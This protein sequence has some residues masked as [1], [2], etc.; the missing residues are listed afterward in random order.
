[1]LLWNVKK[2]GGV[3]LAYQFASRVFVSGWRE[4]KVETTEGYASEG[5]HA[6]LIDS[7]TLRTSSSFMVAQVFF[8]LCIVSASLSDHIPMRLSCILHCRM[9]FAAE[10]TLVCVAEPSDASMLQHFTA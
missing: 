8:C 2:S 6:L 7:L 1:M 4:V 10:S 9:C 5:V 3:L